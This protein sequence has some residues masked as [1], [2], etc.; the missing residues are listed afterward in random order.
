MTGKKIILT[1]LAIMLIGTSQFVYADEA[2]PPAIQME[3]T[4]EGL[5]KLYHKAGL[6]SPEVIINTLEAL[7][8]SREDL[9]TYV[10]QGKKIYDILQEKEVTMVKFKKALTKEYQ[11]RIKEATKYKVITKKEA[12]RLTDLLK[13]RMKE[14][15]I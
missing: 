10:G 12:K 15:E 2:S 9:Q 13:I 11:S 6:D 14:W 4:E 3:E 1:F 5:A 7:G 8:I